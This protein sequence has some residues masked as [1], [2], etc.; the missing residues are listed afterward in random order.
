MACVRACDRSQ[1]DP[2]PAVAFRRQVCD[3]CRG[4]LAGISLNDQGGSRA[5]QSFLVITSHWAWRWKRG[6]TGLAGL[7][8]CVAAPPAGAENG[9]EDRYRAVLWTR[10][11]L[12]VDMHQVL[13]RVAEASGVR[14]D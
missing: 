13:K 11:Y 2:A 4:P 10:R 9:P 8:L 5:S 1:T 6:T 7:R 12:P 14:W 3:N